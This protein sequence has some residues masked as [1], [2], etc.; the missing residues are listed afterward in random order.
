MYDVGIRTQALA[1]VSAGHSLRSVSMALGISRSTLREWRDHPPR[2]RLGECPRCAPEVSLDETAYAHLLGLYLG[3][4]CVSALAKDVYSLR[5]A[6][7][8]A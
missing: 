5:I 3:D 2:P 4:G 7:D 1:A 8:Q 6:C